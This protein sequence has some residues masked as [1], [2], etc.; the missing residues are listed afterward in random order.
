MR[1]EKLNTLEDCCHLLSGPGSEVV[2]ELIAEHRELLKKLDKAHGA[3]LALGL[4]K[5]KLE[6]TISAARDILA[7][8]D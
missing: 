7:N 4:E 6:A 3:Q 1:T 8:S 5:H 2:A